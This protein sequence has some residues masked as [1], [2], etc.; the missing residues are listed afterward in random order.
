MNTFC[1]NWNQSDLNLTFPHTSPS[2]RER[3]V[4]E[5]VIDKAKRKASKSSRTRP[6]TL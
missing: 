2:A 5:W 6:G 3:R 4:R 1:K